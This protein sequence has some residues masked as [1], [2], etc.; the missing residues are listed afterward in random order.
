MKGKKVML[1][2]TGEVGTVTQVINRCL[3]VAMENGTNMSGAKQYWKVV[4]EP[5]AK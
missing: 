4:K 1:R 2:K 5:K 3:F